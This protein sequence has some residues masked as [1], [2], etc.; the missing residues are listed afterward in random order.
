MKFSPTDL[1]KYSKEK[2]IEIIGVKLQVNAIVVYIIT[3]YRSPSGNFNYF[4][5]TLDKILQYINSHNVHIMICG[6]I[7]VNYLKE[8]NQRRK[9][10]NMLHIHNLTSVI[11]FP[12]RI[13][14]ASASAIDSI[15]LDT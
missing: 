14:G 10:D 11:N 2:D 1:Y 15:F 8:N 4:L 9:L 12:T 7:N 3:I 6:D 13:A 5:Q